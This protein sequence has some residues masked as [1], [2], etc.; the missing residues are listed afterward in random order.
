MKAR[1]LTIDRVNRDPEYPLY[2][3]PGYP[4]IRLQGKWLEQ[5][6]FKTGQ[7][8]RIYVTQGKIEILPG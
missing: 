1:W 3:G 2:G 7:K 8:A 4:R 5:A 6:G